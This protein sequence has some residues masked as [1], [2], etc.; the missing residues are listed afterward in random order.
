MDTVTVYVTQS[1]AI[2][3]TADDCRRITAIFDALRIKYDRVLVDTREMM[4]MLVELSG[5]KQ[6]P[7]T[8]VGDQ[9]AG[10]YEKIFGLNET[11]ALPLELRRMG[12]SGDVV[13]GESI[14]VATAAPQTIKKRVVVKKAKPPKE[15]GAAGAAAD[16]DD[17]PPPPPD[18][19][20][21]A[22]A[23]PPPPPDEDAPPPPPDDDDA[24]PPPPPDDD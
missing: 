24:P 9:F 1:N 21:D 11:K 14:P 10:S 19:D 5:S 20:E 4:A 23:P 7:Q 17:A 13:G 8:F 16:D 12:Y 15:P 2:R 3:K 6:L 18:D 22:G